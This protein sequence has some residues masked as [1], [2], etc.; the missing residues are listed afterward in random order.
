MG[1]PEFAVPT[2]R[3]LAGKK[4]EDKL[5]PYEVVGVVTQ[6]DRPLGRAGARSKHRR[7]KHSHWNWA[8]PS[9]NLKNCALPEAMEQI[10]SWAPDLIVVAAFGQ[11]LR[12]DVLGLPPRGCIN[13][14]ASLLPRWRGAAPIQAALMAGDAETGIT[15]MKMDQRRGYRRDHFATCHSDRSGRHGWFADREIVAARCGVVERDTA[16]L[17]IRRAAAARTG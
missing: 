6:P 11:I 10:R 17:F 7:S 15:I 12:P 5:R 1:S 2:L 13:V 14:H 9:F 8:L 16:A 4:D 3:V